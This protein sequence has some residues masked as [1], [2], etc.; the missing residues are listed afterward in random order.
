[1]H[2][3]PEVKHDAAEL[4]RLVQVQLQRDALNTCRHREGS[5][6]DVN[7]R[8]VLSCLRQVISF[9]PLYWIQHLLLFL[10]MPFTARGC[11]VPGDPKAPSRYSPFWDCHQRECPAEDRTFSTRWPL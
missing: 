9:L 7:S 11:G 10:A 3:N 8:E 4:E 5:S 2:T 6:E 1:M